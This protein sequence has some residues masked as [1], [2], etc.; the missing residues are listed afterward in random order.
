MA[1]YIPSAPFTVPVY[2]LIPEYQEIKGVVRKKYTETGPIIFVSFRT[3]G[4][5]EITTNGVYSVIDTA[6]IET[7]YRPDIKSDCQIRRVSD[8]ATYEIIG[9]PEN[10]ELRNQFLKIRVRRIKG[11]A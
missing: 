3:Y 2:L 9:E 8:G 5:T 10:I 6:S 4:G 11:G 1:R 7:W